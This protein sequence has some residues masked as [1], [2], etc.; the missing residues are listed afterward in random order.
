MG[1]RQGWRGLLYHHYF[2]LLRLAVKCE[3]SR[4]CRKLC[5]F[6]PTVASQLPERNGALK[7]L[8]SRRSLI[9]GELGSDGEGCSQ[10]VEPRGW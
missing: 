7:H 2:R 4:L 9:G 6:A 1:G 5:C 8:W 3:V 10:W